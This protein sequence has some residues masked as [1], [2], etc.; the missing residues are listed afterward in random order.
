[1]GMVLLAPSVSYTPERCLQGKSEPSAANGLLFKDDL[2]YGVGELMIMWLLTAEKSAKA[3]AM[4]MELLAIMLMELEVLLKLVVF[5][6]D[7]GALQKLMSWACWKTAS[8]K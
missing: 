2:P 7:E 5:V 6:P 1:M 3:E 4:R 8:C